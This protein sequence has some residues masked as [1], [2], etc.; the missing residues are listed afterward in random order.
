MQLAQHA[1]LPDIAAFKRTFI[2]LHVLWSCAVPSHGCQSDCELKQ[3]SVGQ[4]PIT[5]AA[6][7]HTQTR[8]AATEHQTSNLL[9][10]RGR[11]NQGAGFTGKAVDAPNFCHHG[12][13][14]L[15]TLKLD[16]ILCTAQRS[17]DTIVQCYAGY[18]GRPPHAGGHAKLGGYWN[19]AADAA[20]IAKCA[21]CSSSKGSGWS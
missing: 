6:Q 1:V 2:V 20:P 15:G 10:S 5:S 16:N 13:P 21:R 14:S 18:Q 9:C 3:I 19:P 11:E 4:R 17:G 7:A 8:Q 12:R